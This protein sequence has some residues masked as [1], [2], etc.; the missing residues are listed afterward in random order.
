MIQNLEPWYHVFNSPSNQEN[1]TD[2]MRGES[3]LNPLYGK[4]GTRW[5]RNP[6]R[7]TYIKIYKKTMFSF[8]D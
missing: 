4:K 6:K 7:A 3:S 1:K 8:W 2:G 5:I